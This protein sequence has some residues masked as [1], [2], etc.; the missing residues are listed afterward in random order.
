M[1]GAQGFA[2]KISGRIAEPRKSVLRPWWEQVVLFDVDELSTVARMASVPCI[3]VYCCRRN[4][5][6]SV[7]SESRASN[8]LQRHAN[9]FFFSRSGSTSTHHLRVALPVEIHFF[10]G[11]LGGSVWPVT[12]RLR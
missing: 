9:T 10:L 3:V 7:L 5:L 8:I 12:Q 1:V 4:M 11:V 6:A 2:E